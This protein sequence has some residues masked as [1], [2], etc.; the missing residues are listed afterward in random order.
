MPPRHRIATASALV[1]ATGIVLVACTGGSP[2]RVSAEREAWADLRDA[3][4][5][6]VGRAIVREHD[7]RVTV[8][9]EAT[10]LAPGRHAIHIHQIGR[11]DPPGFD[12]AGDHWNPAGRQH[13]LSNPQGPHAG[14]LPD[15]EA[16]ASGRVR[17]TGVTDGR[18][19]VAPTLGA[20]LDADGSAIVI[21]ARADD[22]RTDPSGNSGD[23]VACGRIT[24]GKPLA[25]PVGRSSP[26]G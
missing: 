21:H 17:Y 18:A 22:Q 3:T 10:G 1:A 2:G 8:R 26:H 24:A 13:G 19:A 16:D 6:S 11:C 14:D 25:G 5:A 23:R 20:L 12:S 15:L 4:G 7:G 9:V